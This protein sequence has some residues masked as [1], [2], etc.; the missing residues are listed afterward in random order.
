MLYELQCLKQE[1]KCIIALA[2][3]TSKQIIFN[4]LKATQPNSLRMESC[5][6]DVMEIKLVEQAILWDL[7]CLMVLGALLDHIL[8]K[9]KP[10]L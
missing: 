6:K 8:R 1:N 3:L 4:K 9:F 2:F 10:I 5:H 7:M